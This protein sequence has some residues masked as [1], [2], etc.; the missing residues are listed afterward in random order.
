MA[1]GVCSGCRKAWWTDLPYGFGLLA[2]VFI[3]RAAAS[4]MRPDGPEWYTILAENAFKNAASDSCRIEIQRR[5]PARNVCL[6]NCLAPWWGDAVSLLLRASSL[7]GLGLDLVA[8]VPRGLETLAPEELA[9]VW[10]VEMPL[11]QTACWNLELAALVKSHVAAFESCAVPSTFQHAF[12]PN[13]EIT[14][15]S[16]VRPFDR[17]GWTQSLQ[18]NPAVT[19]LLREDRCWGA[20]GGSRLRLP[21]RL[22]GAGRINARLDAWAAR[23]AAEAQRRLVLDA[24]RRLR[25]EIPR[26]SVAVCGQDAIGEYPDWIE[27]LRANP[28]KPESNELWM[29]RAAQSHVL[30]TVLGS[31]ATLS[32]S[33]AGAVLTLVPPHMLRNVLTD[34]IVTT[35]SAREAAYLY[36]LLPT[37]ISSAALAEIV[38]S[39][40]FNYPYVRL[41]QGEEC[42]GELDGEQRRRITGEMAARKTAFAALGVAF[43]SNGRVGP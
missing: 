8:L 2:P 32:G 19:F 26:L 25:S 3:D 42:R 38:L 17:A 37:E 6:I 9:E 24:A 30:I 23:R 35:G 41:A 27:D 21:A 16:R 43:E 4:A 14:A 40:L 10:I 18:S 1:G 31:H 13:G 12:Y 28:M 34:T 22:R 36:R 7:F 29:R 5:R 33:H 15:F 20:G 11:A 39:I